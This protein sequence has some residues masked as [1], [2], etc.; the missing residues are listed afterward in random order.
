M[1]LVRPATRAD[2]PSVI[3]LWREMWDLH[4]ALD[5]RFETSPDADRAM[6]EFL[7]GHYD[8]DD[9]RI[10]VAEEGATVVG[11]TLGT[12][13][14]NP[15]V[16]PHPRFGYVADLA[17]TAS[18]RRQ[19]TGARLLAELHAWFRSRGVATAEVQVAVINRESRAFW[20][21]NG[22]TDFLERL[23]RRITE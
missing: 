21:K 14:E 18:A 4:A 19:G 22:Y 20:R 15:P 23:Q 16:I 3:R 10:L 8:S 5:P 17:V 7:D 1:P 2:L 9:S 11:Y 12:I 13:L 6:R